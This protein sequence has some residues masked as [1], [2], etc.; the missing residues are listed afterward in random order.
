MYYRLTGIL[1]LILLFMVTMLNPAYSALNRGNFIPVNQSKSSSAN[2]TVRYY[3]V[4]KGDNLWDISRSFNVSLSQLMALNRVEGNTI[5]SVGQRLKIPSSSVR[6]HYI[7][8]GE[9]MWDIASRYEVSVDGLLSVNPGKNPTRL[10]IGEQLIIPDTR[11]PLTPQVSSR[12]VSFTGAFSWPV[13]GVITS[14]F[15]WRKSGFH[16]GID[17]A[18]DIG[19]PVKACGPGKVVFNGVKPVYGRTLIIEHSDGRQS[20]YAHLQKSV[21]SEGQKVYRGQ[22]VGYIGMTGRT[23]GPHLHFEIRSKNESLNPLN[24]LSR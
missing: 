23:T 12:G 18:G 2:T 9:T 16:H 1:T 15:G 13:L 7:R 22:T 11:Q 20:W 4:K 14:G 21:V 5:L 6:V 19:D 10:A 24:F 8:K 17:I 3:Q